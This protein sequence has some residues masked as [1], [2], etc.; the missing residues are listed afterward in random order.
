MRALMAW[1]A[2]PP[3]RRELWRMIKLVLAAEIVLTLAFVAFVLWN[4]SFEEFAREVEAALRDPTKSEPAAN[5]SQTWREFWTL[6]AIGL[7]SVGI[8]A[9]LVEE[10]I[11]RLIPL[12]IAILLFR[13]TFWTQPLI[14]VFACLTGLIFGL[15]HLGNEGTTLASV[16]V[17]QGT[18]GIVYGILFT[19]VSGMRLSGLWRGY[20]TT[21]FLH[22]VWNTVGVTIVLCLMI[23]GLLPFLYIRL[24]DVPGLFD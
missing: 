9:P 15:A 5:E 19:K 11:F 10:L 14:L 6:F 18:G 7:I 4:G 23:L 20:W 16:L 21:V 1:F 12:G 2:T 24:K 8:I 22:M 17:L 3:T 13:W